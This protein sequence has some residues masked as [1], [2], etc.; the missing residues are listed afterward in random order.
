MESKCFDCEH[1]SGKREDTTTNDIESERL[2]RE[3]L[4][5][6]ACFDVSIA[7]MFHGR[8]GLSWYLRSKLRSERRK[9]LRKSALINIRV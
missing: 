2:E 5:A 8:F 3:V 1:V 7:Q 9:E 6:K 4:I